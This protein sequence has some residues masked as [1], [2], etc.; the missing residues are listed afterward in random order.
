MVYAV[1]D[2]LRGGLSA[3]RSWAA[4]FFEVCQVT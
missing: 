2:L 4:M 3:H 1:R